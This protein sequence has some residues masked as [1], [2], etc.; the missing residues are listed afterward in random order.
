M[1]ELFSWPYQ[2]DLMYIAI[3]NMLNQKLMDIRGVFR[4]LP[5]IYDRDFLQIKD[6]GVTEFM[7]K[8]LPPFIQSDKFHLSN[9]KS[10]VIEKRSNLTKL[11][12]K[13]Q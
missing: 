6:P 9:Q 8:F 5:N 1:L 2:R 12:N 7:K 3:V 10:L 13:I 11:H 4:I